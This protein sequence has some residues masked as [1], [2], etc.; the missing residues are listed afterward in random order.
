[1]C[2]HPRHL[3]KASDESVCC[4]A[5]RRGRTRESYKYITWNHP[6]LQAI[7]NELANEIQEGAIYKMHVVLSV[8]GRGYPFLKPAMILYRRDEVDRRAECQRPPR[9]VLDQP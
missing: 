8:I 1:M 7:M 9:E 6:R 5:H 2:A 3:N 4:S